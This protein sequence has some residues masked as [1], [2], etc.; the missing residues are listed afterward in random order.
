MASVLDQLG[1]FGTSPAFPEGFRYADHVPSAAE[2][3]AVETLRYSI[4]FRT[5]RTVTRD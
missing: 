5:L 1:L 2:E 3:E 4:T